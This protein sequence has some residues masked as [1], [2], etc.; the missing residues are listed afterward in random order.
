MNRPIAEPSLTNSIPTGALLLCILSI[1]D[2][3]R[4]DYLKHDRNAPK[5]KY[6]WALV[7]LESTP[8]LSE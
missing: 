5:A 8:L 2:I 3:L 1:P 7:T 4:K 6:L